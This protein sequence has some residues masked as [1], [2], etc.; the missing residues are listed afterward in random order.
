MKFHY[1]RITAATALVGVTLLA[2][3][4]NTTDRDNAVIGGATGAVIGG[5]TTGTLKGAAVG[6]A[7]GVGAGVL[8]GRIATG[9]LFCRYQRSDGSTYV[10]L[11]P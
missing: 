8:I 3:G 1:A 2:S 5:V 7:V 9:S 11:C 6:T 4:C 10:R